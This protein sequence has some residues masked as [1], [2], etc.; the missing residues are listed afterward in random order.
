[1]TDEKHVVEQALDALV[2]APLGFALEARRLLPTF[3]ERGRAQVQM[4]RVIGKFAVKQGQVEAGRRLNTAQG[5]AGSVLAEYGLVTADPEP[6]DATDLADQ[7]DAVPAS[8][9]T[10]VVEV[11]S[12]PA[13]PASSLAIAGYDSLAASQVIPRLGGLDAA[14]L[15]AVRRYETSNRG[16]KT[17]LGKI[18]QLQTP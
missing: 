18:D 1:V 3:V 6:P 13:P 14:E 16:R 4:A 15:E 2:Y 17:I 5:R 10:V 8:E 11:R 9:D 7:G 12:D